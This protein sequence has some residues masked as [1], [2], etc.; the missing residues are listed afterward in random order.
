M[1]ITSIPAS[2]VVRCFY[3]AF[4]VMLVLSMPGC[5]GGGGGDSGGTTPVVPVVPAQ[6][7]EFVVLAWNDLGMHCL[8]PT[9]DTAVIL[10]PYNT[11]HAQVVRRGNPPQIVTSGV[12]VQYALINN[13]YSYG[14][15]S[16]GQF[17]D[18][19]L[20]LFGVSLPINTGLNLVDPAINN[21]L[22]G[23]M[24][25]KA[26]Y[27]SADGIPVT[28]VNDSNVWNPYQVVQITVKDGSGATVAQTRATVPTSDEINCNR[29][30]GANAFQD[31]LTKHD[32]SHGTNLSGNKPVLCADCHG[33]PVLGTTGT[34]SAGIYLS[35]AIHGFH[36]TVNPAAACYDCHPGPTTQCSRSLAHTTADGNCVACHGGLAT[37]AGSIASGQ[38]VP[39]EAEPK[40]V[41]CHPGVAQVDTGTTLYRAAT[42]HGNLSCEACHGSPH[43]TVPTSQ[44]SDN[45]Q[46]IQYQARAKTIASCGV[47]HDGSRGEGSSEFASEHGGTN[48]RRTTACN[49]CHTAVSSTTAN[50]PH[51]YQWKNR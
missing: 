40:C 19:M 21:S 26:G 8:N 13:T 3:A 1:K 35:Q 32:A 51:A 17:W 24:V 41:S 28:P 29:C 45:Y 11:V 44:A 23:N 47:C 7:S 4:L 50:W 36:S 37:V 6:S 49:V 31:V 46:A 15:R 12:T 27:F 39:W 5:G 10:P 30:H 14:K 42:G 16:Y 43:A 20:Q 22:S 38:R 2:S 9:Y 34:G 25:A 33:S 18:F 48:P